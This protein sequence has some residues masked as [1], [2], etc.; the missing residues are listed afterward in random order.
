MQ[1]ETK[2][3]KTSLGNQSA[4]PKESVPSP[5]S[6]TL[7]GKSKGNS[8][9][10]RFYTVNQKGLLHYIEHVL[11][12]YFKISIWIWIDRYDDVMSTQTVTSAF[13]SPS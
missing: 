5:K 2:S 12:L 1:I 9:I 13:Q 8:V 10:R 7:I 3:E 11:L 6:A 4:R